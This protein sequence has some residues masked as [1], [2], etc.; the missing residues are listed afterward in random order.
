VVAD[1]GRDSS[2]FAN[3]Q[4]LSAASSL[5]QTLSGGRDY[6]PTVFHPAEAQDSI[7]QASDRAASPSHDNNFQAIVMIQVNVRRCQNLTAGVVLRLH[8]FLR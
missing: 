3:R 1:T 6:Q 7:G 2:R 8:Q 5:F 4:E